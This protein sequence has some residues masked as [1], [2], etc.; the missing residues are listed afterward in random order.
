MK[1]KSKSKLTTGIFLAVLSL[2]I[3]GIL[4]SALTLTPT[5]SSLGDFFKVGD[6][7]S[8]DVSSDIPSNFGIVENPIIISSGDSQARFDVVGIGNMENVNSALFNVTLSSITGN[9]PMGIY[10]SNLVIEAEESNLA[11]GEEAEI[12]STTIPLNYV[13]SFC[14]NGP[15]NETN[16]VLD[17]N[18]KNQG[19]GSENEWNPLDKIDVE[20]RVHNN[21]DTDL[22]DVILKIG[23]FERGTTKNV[24]EDMLWISQDGDEYES[25]DIDSGDSSS[26]YTFE[27]RINPDEIDL[28]KTYYLVV[29]AYPD[30]RESTTCVDYSS[31]LAESGD[32]SVKYFGQISIKPEGTKDKMVIIDDYNAGENLVS[33]QCGQEATFSADIYNIGSSD[34]ENKIKVNLFNKELGIDVNEIVLGDLD[35]GDKTTATFK[36]NVPKNIAQKIYPLYMITYYDYR[37]STDTYRYSSDKNFIAYLDVKN[38]VVSSD[39]LVSAS[40]DSEAKSGQEVAVKISLINTA[41]TGRIFVL[42]ASD[43]ESWAEESQKSATIFIPAGGSADSV[44]KLN[45][46]QDAVGE[47]TFNVKIYS[48]SELI[49]TQPVTINI[50]EAVQKKGL[51]G[52]SG[53]SISEGSGYLWGLGIL[54]VI[55]IVLIVIVVLR[56]VRK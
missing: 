9:F 29:K 39:V 4:V 3:L 41:D 26:R 16:L 12:N 13:K 14:R 7:K 42:E 17:V 2:A 53:L 50:E 48:N 31:G 44:L 37:E 45:V 15:V 56:V 55:I 54:N 52:I 11:E 21:K 49:E 38:C 27:F 28:D 30:G 33:A 20:V 32:G 10:S 35:S 19:E 8:V 34:F 47:K 1:S 24:I 43:Y 25:G 36:F 6:L 46:K 40:L 18:V 5:P 22:R 23:L 51:L